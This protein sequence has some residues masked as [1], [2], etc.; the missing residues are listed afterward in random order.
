M[1]LLLGSKDRPDLKQW[2]NH[3]SSSEL[4]NW[5]KGKNLSLIDDDKPVANNS[6]S[7]IPSVGVSFTVTGFKPQLTYNMWVDFVRFKFDKNP[8]IYSKLAVFVDG[9]QVD[10]IVWGKLDEKVL[11]KVELPI[12]LT[13]D[14]ES[15]IT[16]REYAMNYGYWG[17]WDIIVAPGDLPDGGYFKDAVVK[18]EMLVD[19]GSIKVIEKKSTSEKALPETG[20]K[21]SVSVKSS[22][23]KKSSMSPSKSAKSTKKKSTSSASTS[24]KAGITSKQSSTTKKTNSTATTQKKTASSTAQKNTSASPVDE[25]VLP[26]VPQ[27]AEPTVEQPVIPEKPTTN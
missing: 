13:Y 19:T 8:G 6:A 15:T 16:F 23:A 18:Q 3:A 10:E 26:E 5:G 12:D 27:V 7:F 25:P 20:K 21:G 22:S 4:L 1:L 9:R 24:K 2:T 17:V 11:Y 14:G